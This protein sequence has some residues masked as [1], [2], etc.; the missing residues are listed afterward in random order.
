MLKRLALAVLLALCWLQPAAAA[1]NGV[2]VVMIVLD[3]LN[4]WVGYMSGEPGGGPPAGVGNITPNIDALAT[5]GVAFTRAFPAAPI[6]TSSRAAFLGGL[7]PEKTGVYDLNHDYEAAFKALKIVP[8][9]K[10]FMLNGYDVFGHGKIYHPQDLNY[11]RTQFDSWSAGSGAGG[12]GTLYNLKWL[13]RQ[14]GR[15]GNSHCG[16]SARDGSSDDGLQQRIRVHR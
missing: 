6:C 4:D 16:R 13:E 11:I 8:L 10:Q 2:N 5:G 14:G 15:L 12:A 3:D 1:N 7:R 9:T